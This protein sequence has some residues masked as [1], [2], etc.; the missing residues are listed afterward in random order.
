MDSINLKSIIEMALAEDVGHGDITTFNLIEAGQQGCGELLAKS[1]GIIAGLPIAQLVFAS[2]DQDS[3]FTA[4]KHD[5][6]KIE[7]GDKLGMVQGSLRSLLVGERLALNFLQRLSGIATLTNRMVELAGNPAVKILDTRKTT[8]GLRMLEKYAVRVGGGFNHRFGLYD[9]AMVKDNHIIAAGGI[10]EAVQKLKTTIPVTVKIEVEVESLEHMQEALEAGVDIIMLDNMDPALM[11][12]AVELN[13]GRVMLEASGGVNESNIAVIAA[14]GVDAIS[15][16]ALTHS[17][18][19][20]D[21][22]FN[23]IKQDGS[24]KDQ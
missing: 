12:Q 14:T 23:L 7:P 19:S 22:S 4:Y 9:G 8:P 18:N 3:Q 21:I 13:A 5:G 6:E 17:V 15:L 24:I 1:P 10:K 2:L 16:G 11:R 20:L